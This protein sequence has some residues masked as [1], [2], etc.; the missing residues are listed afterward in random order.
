[1]NNQFA[2][3]PGTF[4]RVWDADGD[5]KDIPVVGWSNLTGQLANPLTPIPSM[6]IGKNAMVVIPPLSN[7]DEIYFCH[8]ETGTVCYSG[9]DAESFMSGYLEEHPMP[10]GPE[11]GDDT[12][13]TTTAPKTTGPTQTVGPLHFG[14]QSFKTKSFWHWPE[15]N[16]VFEIEPEQ[17]IPS[18]PRV[19]KVKRDEYAVFKRDG[20]SLIDPHAGADIEQPA[21][22]EGEDFSDV[23]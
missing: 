18:D 7:D 1:M 13:K 17:V 3:Q 15:A 22:D 6:G 14:N 19:K 8:A 10:R 11:K 9:E 2:A 20:A 12:V 23:V 16:A 21:E 4:L 5:T